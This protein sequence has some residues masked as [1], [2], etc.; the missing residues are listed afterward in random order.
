MLEAHAALPNNQLTVRNSRWLKAMTRMTRSGCAG[1][2]HHRPLAMYL[3]SG[4]VLIL[5]RAAAGTSATRMK[6]PA[7][8]L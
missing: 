7:T 6:A 2:V 1:N 8:I 5:D 4:Q 3:D